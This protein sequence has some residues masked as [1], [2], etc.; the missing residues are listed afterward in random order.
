MDNN[1]YTTET[2]K[3]IPS[4]FIILIILIAGAAITAA[5]R[6][7]FMDWRREAIQ[8]SNEYVES[9][10]TLLLGLVEDWNELEVD[11]ASPD[12]SDALLGAKRNQQVAI[13]ARISSEVERLPDSE[14]PPS[15]LTFLS[16]DRS[17]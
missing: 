4:F 5:V 17:N 3:W 12:A 16:L 11:L 2:V 8:H 13:A 9:K 6:P 14:V 7:T 15:V 1:E 10:A